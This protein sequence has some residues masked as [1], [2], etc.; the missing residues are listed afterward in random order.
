M[1][2]SN[3]IVDKGLLKLEQSKG[4]KAQVGYDLSL[5]E[6]NKIGYTDKQDG[7]IGKVLVDKTELATY[8]PMSKTSL[9]GKIG[10]LL[11]SGAY[12]ITFWEGCKIPANFVGLIR[13]RSSMLRNGTVLHSS[14]FDPGFETEFMGTVMVVNETIFIEEDARVA[15]IY[16]HTCE[17]VEQENLYNGQWQGDK[18]R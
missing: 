2:N 15:Q 1:L 17:E 11:Y 6:V 3:Q 12:D 10:W 18:Q 5:K 13:Q 9:D 4:K 7:K 16:F 8:T 14:V